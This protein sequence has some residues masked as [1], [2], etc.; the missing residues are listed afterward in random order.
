M[1]ADLTATPG[2]P[3]SYKGTRAVV[4]QPALHTYAG[5]TLD[6][7]QIFMMRGLPNDDRLIRLGFAEKLEKGIETAACPVCG[8]TFGTAK[9]IGSALRNRDAH[10]DARH[11]VRDVLADR[12]PQL[13]DVSKL[14]EDSFRGE[15]PDNDPGSAKD[16]PPLYLDQTA[17]SRGVKPETPIT[18]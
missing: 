9:G 6:K 15:A 13:G 4:R 16:A 8:A 1:A 17:A 12:A 7:G 3:A 11:V 14:T 2:N 5:K 10:A 18:I